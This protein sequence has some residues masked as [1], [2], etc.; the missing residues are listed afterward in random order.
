MNLDRL[1]YNPFVV[2][3]LWYPVEPLVEEVRVLGRGRP[4]SHT[5]KRRHGRESYRRTRDRQKVMR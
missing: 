4:I 1:T 2:L 5:F 3:R